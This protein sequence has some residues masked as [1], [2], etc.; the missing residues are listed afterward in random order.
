MSV[1]FKL[2]DLGEGI[3]EGE[4]LSIL[5]V[6]GDKVNEGDPIMEVETDKAAVEIPS[7]FTATVTEIRVKPGMTVNVGDVMVVF[8]ETDAQPLDAAKQPATAPPQPSPVSNQPAP[9]ASQNAPAAAQPVA[10]ASAQSESEA[11]TAGKVG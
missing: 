8:D 6:V 10:A 5:V 9:E 4:V 2:P 1:V 7:P 11:A 3:H